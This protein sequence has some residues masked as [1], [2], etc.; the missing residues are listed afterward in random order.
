MKKKEHTYRFY[1]YITKLRTSIA[2]KILFIKIQCIENIFTL[3][4]FILHEQKICI[5]LVDYLIFN[6]FLVKKSFYCLT[7]DLNVFCF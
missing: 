4:E 6:L 7:H 3:H 2:L 1:H 5:Y